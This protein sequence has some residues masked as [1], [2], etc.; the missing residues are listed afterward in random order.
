MTTASFVI[1][2]V[3]Y[4]TLNSSLNLLNKV[5][6]TAQPKCWQSACDKAAVATPPWDRTGVL[7]SLPT[8]KEDER[9][10]GIASIYTQP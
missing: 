8:Q 10:L 1:L 9:T 6:Q 3:T 4:L 7:H 2:I 5:R